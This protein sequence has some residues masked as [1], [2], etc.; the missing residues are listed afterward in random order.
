MVMKK[1]LKML[2]ILLLCM[3]IFAACSDNKN[4]NYESGHNINR[5][6]STESGLIMD[7]DSTSNIQHDGKGSSI[8]KMDNADEDKSSDSIPSS[9]SGTSFQSTPDKNSTQN[10]DEKTP[11][12]CTVLITCNTIF[13]NLDKFDQTKLEVLPKD[14]IVYKAEEVEFFEGDSAFDVL[15]RLT[16][17]KRIHM[18]FTETPIYKS[19]Y[20]EGINNIY[21]FD[22]GPLS[23]WMYKV[24]D[25]FPNCGSSRY[26]LEDGDVIEWIYTCDLGADIGG[27]WNAQNSD[28]G[29]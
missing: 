19:A 10:S 1:Y 13:D 7:S 8:N 29:E 4:D 16:R 15:L 9:G 20:I 28:K 21:E 11:H 25:K 27:D 23:G 5:N 17:H 22:S 6:S 26:R 2:L 18:E 3:T 24:N 12:Y 14:G